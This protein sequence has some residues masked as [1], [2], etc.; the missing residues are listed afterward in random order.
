ESRV[1]EAL[2]RPRLPHERAGSAWEIR[3]ISDPNDD[4]AP[5]DIL[6]DSTLI[7]PESESLSG[8]RTRRIVTT[9]RGDRVDSHEAPANESAPPAAAPA[10]PPHIEP[11]APVPAEPTSGALATLTY[12]DENGDHL[13]RMETPQVVVASG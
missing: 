1:R 5:G 2:R 7:L 4:L 11:P 6:V 9:R 13:F 8:S 3:L 10:N 12:R